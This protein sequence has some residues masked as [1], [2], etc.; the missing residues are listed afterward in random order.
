VRKQDLGPT[1]KAFSKVYAFFKKHKQAAGILGFSGL[2]ALGS[3]ALWNTISGIP[4]ISLIDQFLL[5]L[6][7][8]QRIQI[9]RSSELQEL[10]D[11]AKYDPTLMQMSE[12]FMTLLSEKQRRLVDQL[13]V[14][15]SKNN[16]H[17]AFLD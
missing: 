1:K 17:L 16:P 5:S 13:V 14:E 10:L 2:S 12:P 8:Q 9:Q 4:P 7:A 11:Q 15:Y 3:Y 6:T